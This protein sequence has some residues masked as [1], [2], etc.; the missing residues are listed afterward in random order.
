MPDFKKMLDMYKGM[1][2]MFSKA[3]ESDPATAIAEIA[4]SLAMALDKWQVERG[5][6]LEATNEMLK[7]VIETRIDVWRDME[8]EGI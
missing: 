3:D 8:S 6:S 1:H 4:S 2:E 5:F 7:H